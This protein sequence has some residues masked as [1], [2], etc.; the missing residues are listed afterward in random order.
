M[1]ELSR[2]KSTESITFYDIQQ[3]FNEYWKNKEPEKGKGYKPFKRWE[4]FM[5]PRIHPSGKLSSITL[6]QAIQ[7]KQNAKSL[8]STADVIWTFL[9]PSE[10]SVD[11][12]SK[13]IGGAG[14]INCIAF[15][16][17]DSSIMWTGAPSGGIWITTDGGK[18]WIPTGDQ[19]A[20]IGISDIAV[21]PLNPD[22][23]YIATG[24]GDAMDTYSIGILKS[25]DG[26]VTWTATKLT[27]DVSETHAFRKI[28]MY[29]S[30]P[31]IMIATAT[32]GIYRTITG[33]NSYTR[34]VAGSFR[35]LE[36]K[37]GNPAVVYATSYSSSGNAKIY[38]STSQGA[39]FNLSM[40]GMNIT[41]KV[42]R[43]ELAVS[44][45]DP[46][47]VYALC[48]DVQNDGFYALYKSTNSGI[49]WTE[50]YGNGKLNLLGWSVTGSDV[51]GQGWYDLSMAVSPSNINE[52]YVGGVNVWRSMNGGSNWTLN[53]N[54]FHDD[55]NEYVH[56]D[57][58]ILVYSPHREIL[59]SGNDG[60][61]SKTYNSGES[62][63][64]I[65]NDLNILQTYRFG[66]SALDPDLII[67]GNQDNGS[68]L[69]DGEN[70]FEVVGGDGMECFTDYTDE[71]II[72][73][74]MYNGD[75]RKSINKGISFNS[76]SP[77]GSPEGAWVTP[78]VMH[79]YVPTILYAGYE[80]IYKS[81]NGGKSWTEMP[82]SILGNK[83]NALA[84]APSNDRYLYASSYSTI[85]KSTD[86]GKTWI[87]ITTKLPSSPIS[88]IAVSPTDPNKLWIT[89]ASYTAGMKVFGTSDGGSSWTNYSGGLPNIPVNCIVYQK[90]SPGGLYAGTD[91]GVYYR[92]EQQTEWTDYSGN[93]PNVIITD[94]EIDYSTSLL[95]AATYGR[96]IWQTPVVAFDPNIIR[97]DFSVS[98][99]YACLNGT[100]TVEDHSLGNPTGYLW[101]FGANAIPATADT[102]GPHTVYYTTTGKKNISLSVTKDT[103]NDDETKNSVVEVG[104]TIDFVVSPN[105]FNSCQQIP[106]SVYVTGNFSYDV[107]PSGGLETKDENKFTVSPDETTIYTVTAQHGTCSAQRNAT[108]M[109]T[110]NDNVCDAIPL[111]Y[112]V[113]G[114]F[115]N[116]CATK[117]ETEPVPPPGSS[118]DGC[119]TQDGWCD[120]EDRIDNS[121]WFTF[122][123]PDNGL[124]SIGSHGFDN[125]IAIYSASSCDDILNS[126]YEMLAAN[127]DFPSK[128]DYS[129][130]IEELSGLT[131]G[132]TYWVQ[133]DG[134]YGGVSGTFTLTL[135]NGPLSGIIEAKAD[136]VYPVS[137]YPN[138]S[139]EGIFNLSM[140]KDYHSD[141]QLF[142]RNVNGK[143][144]YYNKEHAYTAGTVIPVNLSH[145]H[146]GLYL[147]EIL[148]DDGR[149]HTKITIPGR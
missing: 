140:E 13:K 11:I 44:P 103:G 21:D 70:Y 57:H 32:D 59:F 26:G 36:F 113:N 2:K 14:R 127:D 110:K 78:F 144:V 65:S 42:N 124:V 60:G 83:I 50:I 137:I 25:T 99:T 131:P 64:D 28:L 19:L 48:S 81:V 61:I 102:K 46:D 101:N 29:P 100:I 63:Q 73:A 67:T 20:A 145:L 68:I 27:Q 79:A 45:A 49:S 74:T 66:L 23:L 5:E 90:G 114:P 147:F 30:S 116:D 52:I 120:G 135:T 108:V 37:P 134:S 95:K 47:V 118:G 130:C 141:F 87:N 77:P 22:N 4:Y 126:N 82:I 122:I 107:S 54:W 15:H 39:T 34:V 121:L 97:A 85:V 143:I 53:C 7:E 148:F 40:T 24:D 133:I 51:G 93:L 17:T 138:P 104:S 35:D 12:N 10:V 132:V 71:N 6:W 3:A 128:E 75:L 41:G 136:L 56:A 88:S 18:H 119:Q 91:I 55:D 123:A 31:E 58:H 142:I 86:G 89:Y 92:D 62:W 94:L 8:W 117:E 115:D 129:G 106:V 125:Q 112:G 9:G 33:W 96:G 105:I 43:I 16:P 84:V 149:Y 98:N 1:Y 69:M 111:Q 72:Y 76:I 139:Q 109:V 146:S 38:K 80:D